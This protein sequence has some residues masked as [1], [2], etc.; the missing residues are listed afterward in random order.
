MRRRSQYLALGYLIAA[1]ANISAPRRGGD[2]ELLLLLL[3]ALW[4]WLIRPT[5]ARLD[6]TDVRLLLWQH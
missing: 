6:A 3:R 2:G 1:G 5:C 4:H